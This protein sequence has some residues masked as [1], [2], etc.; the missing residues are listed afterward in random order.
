MLC[1]NYV[2]LIV[3]DVQVD[4]EESRERLAAGKAASR[5]LDSL[6]L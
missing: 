1:T 6:P 3:G 2:G 4:G 5:T